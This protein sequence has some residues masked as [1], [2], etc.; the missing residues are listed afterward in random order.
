[1]DKSKIDGNSHLWEVVGMMW[2]KRCGG[3]ASPRISLHMLGVIF[4]SVDGARK[5]HKIMSLY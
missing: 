1:M 3:S 4:L 2:R 5:P